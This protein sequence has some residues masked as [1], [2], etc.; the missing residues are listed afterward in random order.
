MEAKLRNVHQRAVDEAAVDSAWVIRHLKH[1]ALMAMRGDPV[2]DRRGQPTGN[3]R[4]DRHAANRALELLGRSVGLFIEKVEVGVP[5]DFSQM[6]DP[7]LIVKIG[8]AARDCGLPEE[9]ISRITRDLQLPNLYL[10]DQRSF[11]PSRCTKM[12]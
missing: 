2:F 6:S 9:L 4:P 5:G 11:A 10:Y 12:N 7:E 3:F 1:N 8:E